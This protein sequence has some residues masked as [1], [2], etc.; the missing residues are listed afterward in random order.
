MLTSA[1]SAELIKHA[2]NAFLAMK[3]SFANAVAPYVKAWVPTR[4]RF[5]RA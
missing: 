5:A 1:N 4:S 2:S 3:I